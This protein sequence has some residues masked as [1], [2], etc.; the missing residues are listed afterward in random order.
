[1]TNTVPTR[2]SIEVPDSKDS[3]TYKP[4]ISVDGISKS[5]GATKVLDN[6]SF[7]VGRRLP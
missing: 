6:L 3:Q 2:P 7:T 1:M 5:F 4:I